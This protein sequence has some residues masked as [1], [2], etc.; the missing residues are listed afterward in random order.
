MIDRDVIDMVD[1]QTLPLPREGREHARARGRH[2]A[3]IVAVATFAKDTGT[4]WGLCP[5]DGCF[6]WG[7]VTAKGVV[8]RHTTQDTEY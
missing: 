8:P 6:K 1:A 3:H 2:P 5:H 4:V 7:R